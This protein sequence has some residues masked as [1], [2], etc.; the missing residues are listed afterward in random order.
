VSII[1]RDL[2]GVC[3][4]SVDKNQALCSQT[5]R[6]ADFFVASSGLAVHGVLSPT[7]APRSTRGMASLAH[8]TFWFL[9]HSNRADELTGNTYCVSILKLFKTTIQT[10]GQ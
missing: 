8:V 9:K 3:Y 10:G 5:Q 6:A 4:A 1:H 2:A 7:Q